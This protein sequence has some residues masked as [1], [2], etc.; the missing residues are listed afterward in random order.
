M[1]RLT[2]ILILVAS[3]VF[4]ATPAEMNAQRDLAISAKAAVVEKKKSA[5]LVFDVTD[6]IRGLAIADRILSLDPAMGDF[7][8]SSGENFRASGQSQYA[9]GC[10]KVAIADQL[11]AEAEV[12]RM[13]FEPTAA[14]PK[15]YAAMVGYDSS[16]LQEFAYASSYWFA[17]SMAYEIAIQWYQMSQPPLPMP[18]I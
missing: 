13:N 17:A 10:S 3:T 16:R 4:G 6:F 8:F 11:F 2:L 9:A 14:T 15:Y 7:S 12:H 1:K 5:L 18:M